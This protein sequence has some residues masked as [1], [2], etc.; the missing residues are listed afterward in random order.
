FMNDAPPA[1]LALYAPQPGAHLPAPDGMKPFSSLLR[2]NDAGI[3]GVLEDWLHGVYVAPGAAEA[4]AE[5][6]R[7]PQGA[8]FVTREGHVVT[9]S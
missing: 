3:R 5:R 9:R 8:A 2:V 6:A 4:F 1:R 7:L